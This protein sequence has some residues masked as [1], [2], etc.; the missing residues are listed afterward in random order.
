MYLLTRAYQILDLYTKC[1]KCIA[2]VLIQSGIC[3]KM[4]VRRILQ[5]I[6]SAATDV[7]FIAMSEP[8][9]IQ[10]GCCS[11]TYYPRCPSLWATTDYSGYTTLWRVQWWS[12]NVEHVTYIEKNS[13]QASARVTPLAKRFQREAAVLL[14]RGA[15]LCVST[16]WAE[17]PRPLMRLWLH[18]TR[19]IRWCDVPCCSCRREANTIRMAV[20][21]SIGRVQ[22]STN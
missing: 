7:G 14:T 5:S 13:F 17:W 22:H 2:N 18:S 21:C 4:K 16:R 15:R 10:R 3:N 19:C 9:N 12:T 1:F 11:E 20:C 8:F 6:F